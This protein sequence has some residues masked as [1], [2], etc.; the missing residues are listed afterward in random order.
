MLNAEEKRKILVYARELLKACLSDGPEPELELDRK[1]MEQKRGIFVT[2]KLRGRLRGCIGHILGDEPLGKSIHQMTLAAAF[3]DPRFPP[4][5]LDELEDIKIH[6][7]LLTEPVPVKSYRDI[8]TG[9]DGIIVT[10]GW[11]K[12][13]YLPEVAT[14][15]GWNSKTFFESCALEKAGLTEQELPE[16]MIEVFQTEGF[17]D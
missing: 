10:R 1:V 8:R 11:K 12:G 2:L 3:E 14:E 15:T 4:L 16:A 13:V 5:A 6:I 17:E 7:S 9:T